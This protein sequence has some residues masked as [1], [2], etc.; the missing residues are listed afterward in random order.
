MHYILH[1]DKG[2]KTDVTYHEQKKYIHPFLRFILNCAGHHRLTFV[3]VFILCICD[4]VYSTI[5]VVIFDS[6]FF[7]GALVL[8]GVINTVILAIANKAELA[9]STRVI[10]KIPNDAYEFTM[11]EKSAG[12]PLLNTYVYLSLKGIDSIISEAETED[13][14][15][16]AVKLKMMK[17][18]IVH[19]SLVEAVFVHGSVALAVYVWS[20][21]SNVKT[22]LEN[23]ETMYAMLALLVLLNKTVW[24]ICSCQ[25]S[26]FL[27]CTQRLCELEVRRV[28]GDLRNVDVLKWKEGFVGIAPRV[29][30]MMIECHRA[31]NRTHA[32]FVFFF[33]TLVL[34]FF[35]FFA[36]L[37]DSQQ[38]TE[39]GEEGCL[40]SWIFVGALQPLIS[41]LVFV[42]KF[43][44]L[45]LHLERDMGMDLM[46][47][48]L[49]ASLVKLPRYLVEQL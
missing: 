15:R 8:L 22:H 23:E 36:G 3:P 29:K 24:V 16:D 32:F 18:R 39:G 30:R 42:H 2:R 38:G 31:A 35:L 10:N 37:F 45:N 4:I 47:L 14:E 1:D 43:G 12:G 27:R 21:L 25:I 20:L 19:H 9:A 26:F 11:K 6:G 46:E 44:T 49:R 40:P 41:V 28:Q 34:H 7:A 17:D 13:E 33:P 48:N 5:C